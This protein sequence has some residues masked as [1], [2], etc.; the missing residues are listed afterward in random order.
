[1]AP[2][3]RSSRNRATPRGRQQWWPAPFA[4]S[5]DW[6]PMCT[7]LQV[8]AAGLR[9]A[10][11]DPQS[12]HRVGVRAGGTA[13]AGRDCGTARCNRHAIRAT[14]ERHPGERERRRARGD[15]SVAGRRRR[16]RAAADADLQPLPP[17]EQPVVASDDAGRVAAR[18]RAERRQP[19]AGAARRRAV[20]RS[21]RRLGVLDARAARERWTGSR[22]WTARARAST[23][24]TPWAASST[25][26]T[27]GPPADRGGEVAVRIAAEPEVRPLRQ[28]RLGQGRGRGRCELVSTRTAFRS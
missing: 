18:H 3:S 8:R 11:D 21:V 12:A 23:A 17:D 27:P 26:S 14:D 16:R 13:E 28:R 2:R 7:R 5:T 6:R 20:Q 24:T 10:D 25:S 1:M 9:R 19:H 15:R 22:S 4:P